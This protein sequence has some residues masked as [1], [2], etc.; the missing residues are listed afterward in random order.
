MSLPDPKA[1]D[2]SMITFFLMQH[3]RWNHIGEA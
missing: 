3:M 2:T 1:V